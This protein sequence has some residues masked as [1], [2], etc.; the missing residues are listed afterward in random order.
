VSAAEPTPAGV[1]LVDKPAG[2]T[3]HDVVAEIRRE[4]GSKVG[5]AGTLDPFAT[6][7]LV[8]L[9]GRATR[10]Q[11]YLLRLPKTYRATARLG[12]RS[13]TGDP[14]GELTETGRIPERLELPTGEIEQRVPMT[15]A[16]KVDGERLYRKA[17]RGEEVDTPTRRVTIHRAELIESDGERATFEIECS[18]GTYI[19]TLI[20]TLGDA[21]CDSLRRTA[22]DDLHVP[23]EGRVEVSPAELMGFLPERL[24][25]DEEATAVSHGRP[26]VEPFDIPPEHVRLTHDGRLIAV[27]RVDG[28]NL[29]PEVVLV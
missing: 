26:V 16:V 24:L 17:H 29:Q 2:V 20:E 23:E 21:Y 15:S 4:S 1:L 9:L 18:S 14:D 13:S 5:H 27:A 6:G 11:R 7:L 8:I 19:R 22:I 12:W 3:S 10:L 28:E 25:D